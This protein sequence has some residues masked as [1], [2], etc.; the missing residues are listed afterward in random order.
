MDLVR[1]LRR[2]VGQVVTIFT[3]SGGESGRGFT[4]VLASVSSD[5]IVRLITQIGPAPGCALGS[6][7]DVKHNKKR[8]SRRR[9]E[10]EDENEVSEDELNENRFDCQVRSVGA[11]VDIPVNRIVAFVH[12][13]I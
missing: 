5:P 3:T 7:C 13:S 9:F 2:F 12:S 10:D 1:E 4:G 11:V 8:G 6:C